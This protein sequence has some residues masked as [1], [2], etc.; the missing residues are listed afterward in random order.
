[1]STGTIIVIVVAVVV[2]AA[3]VTGVMTIMRRRRLQQRFGPEYDRL[4]GERDSKLKAETELAERER[5]VEGLDIRPLTDSARE[6]YAEQW[7]GIQER[8]VDTPPDAVSASQVLVVAVMTERGYPAEDHD[9]VLAD[10]SVEHA[11]MLDHYRAAERSAGVPL[12]ARPR[13][14]TCGWP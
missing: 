2:V 9:Q 3:L 11:S 6:R 13:R 14:R 7:A 12:R 1:M 10:L 5:R 8:F 4:A